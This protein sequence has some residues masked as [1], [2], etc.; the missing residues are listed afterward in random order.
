MSK[1]LVEQYVDDPNHMRLFQQERA[2]YEA[3]ELIESVMKRN[4]VSRTELAKQLGK[5]KGWVTQLLDGEANKTIRTVAD[6]LAVL[7][8]QLRSSADPIRI[9]NAT[10]YQGMLNGKAK[11]RQG[12][13]IKNQF[14]PQ[15]TRRQERGRRRKT[16]R[17]VRE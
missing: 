17:P 6:V 15:S 14:S 13:P 16:P 8:F 10:S 9:S 7:G 3:T 4:G 1:T 5:S 12:D 11:P 2:I